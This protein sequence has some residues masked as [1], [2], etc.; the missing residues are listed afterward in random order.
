MKNILSVYTIPYLV[1]LVVVTG[2]MIAYPKLELHLMLN[3]HHTQLQDTFFKYY[4]VLAE[5]PLYVL[6]FIPLCF[7]QFRVTIFFAISE[8]LAGA[9]SYSVK[10]SISTDRPMRAFESYPDMVLPLVEGVDLHHSNSFPSGHTSTFFVFFTVCAI[11]LAY[12]YHQKADPAN[13]KTRIWTIVA[14]LALLILAVLGGYSR[15]Y[16]SQHFLIDV[17]VGS[18]IGFAVT[19]IV[20]FFGKNKIFKTSKEN[21]KQ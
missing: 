11:V 12:Y 15:V 10:H 7:K 14:L 19:Y 8:M 3:S 4:S 20:Y 18:L 2:L 17:T 5:W 16:L 1:L 21:E 13:R 6:M 9:I